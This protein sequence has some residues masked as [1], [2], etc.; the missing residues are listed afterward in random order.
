MAIQLIPL[1]QI[2]DNPFNSRTQY[3]QER[4]KELASSIEQNGLQEIPKAHQLALDTYELAFGGYRLRAF[5]LLAKKDKE[6][7][8]S[9]PIDIEE[10]PDTQMAILSIEENLKRND[11]TPMEVAYAIDKYF[12][13]FPDE[14]EERLANKL[15]MTQGAISNMRRVV[16][17]PK[18]VLQFVDDKKINFTMA[19]ELCTLQLQGLEPSFSTTRTDE[20]NMLESINCM[21]FHEQH[22]PN[23]IDGIRRAIHIIISRHYHTLDKEAP[24]GAPLFDPVKLKCFKCT[25]CIKTTETKGKSSFHCLDG[26]CWDANQEGA[27]RKAEDE[28][29][30]KKK[31]EEE[32]SARKE[33]ER[34]KAEEETQPRIINLVSS[35]RLQEKGDIYES[36]STHLIKAGQSINTPFVDVENSYISAGDSKNIAGAKECY[37]VVPREAFT[38]ETRTY[39][40]PEGRTAEE[41]HNEIQKDPYGPFNG[42]LIKQVVN[43]ELRDFVMVGPPVIFAPTEF[44]AQKPK[45]IPKPREPKIRT[46]ITPPVAPVPSEENV[47]TK[48][49]VSLTYSVIIDDR[50]IEEKELKSRLV[51]A[52]KE[53]SLEDEDEDA[54]F[55]YIKES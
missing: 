17:L 38:D 44:P 13:T 19:R 20:Q 36:Y 21:L 35:E 49:S 25:K 30:A 11:L 15:S 31:V 53:M 16:K 50:D 55:T 14:T 43:G 29:A 54:H 47:G 39:N 18:E 3:D 12:A 4:V 10:I 42:M 33:A 41:Y 27:R 34:I 45:P 52:W 46:V 22:I 9:M 26:S 6:K 1:D 5:K 37:R 40:P 51:T 7:W 2:H 24:D 32:E 28:A 48:Y 8:G 23:T